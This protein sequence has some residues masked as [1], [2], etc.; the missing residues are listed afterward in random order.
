MLPPNAIFRD[1]TATKPFAKH[2]E[3]LDSRPNHKFSCHALL[4][5]VDEKERSLYE[6]VIL[7]TRETNE[8]EN[9]SDTQGAS[10]RDRFGGRLFFSV[11]CVPLVKN[12][13]PFLMDCRNI[14]IS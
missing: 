4:G 3:N 9:P 8:E 12:I 10:I 13:S 1:S 2:H 7:M 11:V 14:L 5:P 6:V